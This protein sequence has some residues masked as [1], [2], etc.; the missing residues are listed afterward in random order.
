MK[1]KESRITAPQIKD[2]NEKRTNQMEL[3]IR[4]ECTR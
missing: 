4:M 2:K 3:N 1:N